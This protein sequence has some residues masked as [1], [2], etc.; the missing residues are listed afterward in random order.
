M[1]DTTI[2]ILFSI[3]CIAF[4]FNKGVKCSKCPKCFNSETKIEY[5]KW[6]NGIIN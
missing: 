4:A 5:L 6:N 1:L 2:F 3:S